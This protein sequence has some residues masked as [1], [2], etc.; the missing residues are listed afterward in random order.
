MED[1]FFAIKSLLDSK[2]AD[3]ELF[4]HEPVYTSEQAARVRDEPL[5]SG[6]KSLVFKAREEFV[7]VLVPGDKKVD[8]GKLRA[9]TNK[10]DIRMATPEE[11]L[12]VCSCEVG[13]VHPFGNLM[14]PGLKI[15]MDR[16]IL[17]NSRVNFNVGL[18]TMTVRMS[19]QNLKEIIKP[20][21]V[22]LMK[23]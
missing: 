6:V 14:G 17:Q 10:N 12:K 7:L 16:S 11:V 23:E 20:E 13:S 22:D 4:E 18:H 2:K 3:Y 8:V 15:Y 21:V 5:R 19:P 9:V 1:E